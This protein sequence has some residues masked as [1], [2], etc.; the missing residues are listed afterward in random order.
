MH[1]FVQHV[2]QSCVS[3]MIEI[4]NNSENGTESALSKFADNA[5]VGRMISRLDNIQMVTE[6]PSEQADKMP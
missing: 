2:E 3:V 4:C 6:K 5:E 1:N